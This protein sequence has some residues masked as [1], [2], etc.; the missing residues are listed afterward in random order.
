M[1]RG[2][3]NVLYTSLSREGAMAELTYHWGM[4]SP[5]P[6][7]PAVIN[8]IQVDITSSLRILRSD[9]DR[10]G[11]S[12]SDYEQPNH[13]RMQKIGA[14]VAFLGCH[15]LIVPSARWLCENLIIFTE[16]LPSLDALE[17]LEVNE[18]DWQSWGKKNNLLE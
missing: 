9:F 11:I 7:K 2:E 4:L 15:G 10:L 5:L 6:S 14:I 17:L 18:I 13:D 16:N 1:P 12:E 3:S 8:R